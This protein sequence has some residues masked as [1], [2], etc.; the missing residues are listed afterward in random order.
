MAC[1]TA[2]SPTDV[3]HSAITT[4]TLTPLF[5][6]SSSDSTRLLSLRPE[7]TSLSKLEAIISTYPPICESLFSQLP[8][9]SIITLY[10]TS[11]PLRDFLHIYPLAWRS[12]SFRSFVQPLTT[13]RQN[14][15]ANEPSTQSTISSSSLY[16]LDLLLFNIVLPFGHRLTTLDLDNTTISGESLSQCVLHPRRHT[17]QHLSVRGC[18]QVSLKYHIVPFLTLFKLQASSRGPHGQEVPS[19]LALKSLYAFRC[20]HHRRRPYT[21]SSR[22]RK[23]SDSAPTHDL[24]LLCRDLGIWTD[25]AWCPT[26]GGRCVRRKDYST[27]RGTP[28]AR[29]EVWVVFDRLW[30]SGN[31]LGPSTH[32]DGSKP[33]KRTGQFWEEAEEGYDGEPLGCEPEGKGLPAHL[34]KS[35]T[36]FV[37]S[38]KCHDCGIS[39]EER[40]EHCSLR[41]HCAGCRKTL[42][43]NCAFVRPLPRATNHERNDDED[44]WWAPSAMRSPN[45]M[46]QEVDHGPGQT[47]TS[48]LIPN[49]TLTPSLKTQWCCAK[50]TLS[51]G[52]SIN[53][54]EPMADK[55]SIYQ[56]RAA[57]IPQ[58]KDYLD[59]DFESSEDHPGEET[60]VP[61]KGGN[62][63]ENCMVPVPQEEALQY[64]LNR[65][66][67]E[68]IACSR[69]L[70]PECWRTPKWKGSC[71][72]CNQL[73][74]FAHDFR[75]NSVRICGYKD[76]SK[77]QALLTVKAMLKEILEILEIC[78]QTMESY[79]DSPCEIPEDPLIQRLKDERANPDTIKLIANALPSLKC[80]ADCNQLRKEV[81]RLLLGG[82]PGDLPGAVDPSLQQGSTTDSEE[83]DSSQTDD[84]TLCGEEPERWEGC[85]SF[86]CPKFRRV[87]DHRPSC[88]AA[89]QQCVKCSTHICPDC[90]IAHPACDCSYC[91]TNYHCPNCFPRFLA[92]DGHCQK[93]EEEKQK[94]LLEQADAVALLVGEFM[95][96]V[97]GALNNNLQNEQIAT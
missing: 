70:C 82:S 66:G 68:S 29:I 81:E 27:T 73:L 41:M 7:E 6:P 44:L 62:S 51:N 55:I 19:G 16:C 78:D 67:R 52:G 20:R 46:L 76:I 36:I 26:V 97:N 14:S 93:A 24:I 37:E 42:C 80:C 63:L 47:L 91:Q 8:T 87:A 23:D 77:E 12:L 15:P 86:M 90:L 64:L 40:C 92:E 38:I 65:P 43:Q 57:P 79:V 22:L 74:C 4:H 69:N 10:H 32:T 72:I 83:R 18:K 30:R 54:M 85:G 71:K 50:P 35:H 21:P 53:V 34:R 89:A 84:N 60:T 9:A 88:T 61:N 2:A 39:I 13:T 25:S 1:S 45:L 48:G 49:S 75:G 5:S 33:A 58:S 94:R 28:E 95:R 56:L 31:R 96:S 11:K 59:P 17:L 3:D